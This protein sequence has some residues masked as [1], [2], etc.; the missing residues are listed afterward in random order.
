MLVLGLER[1]ARDAGSGVVNER[2]QRAE[3]GD[4]LRDA[5]GRD[6]AAHERRLGAARTQLVG[7]RLC[8]GVLAHV[9]DRHAFRAFV[10]EAQRDLAADPA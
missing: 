3:G 5:L 1:R 4:L 2:V 6:V 10:G 8:G 9:A 7:D